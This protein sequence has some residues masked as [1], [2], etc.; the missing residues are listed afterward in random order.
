MAQP[1]HQNPPA[2]LIVPGIADERQ[3]SIGNLL[4]LLQELRLYLYSPGEQQG[5]GEKVAVP[6]VVSK[7]VRLSVETTAMKVLGRIDS[8]I[9]N[10]RLWDGRDMRGYRRAMA[11]AMEAHTFAAY[12]TFLPHN[13]HKPILEKS[14]DGL[15]WRSILGMGPNAIAGEGRTPEEALEQFDRNFMG[16]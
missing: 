2:N 10:P 6:S 9:D 8:I 11:E 4:G 15:T 5:F 12:Q 16:R 14:E 1:L 7:E 3:Q 13:Q